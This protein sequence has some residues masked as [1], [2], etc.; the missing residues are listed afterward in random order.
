[1]CGSGCGAVSGSGPGS[2]SA[3]SRS[4]GA[5]AFVWRARVGAGPLTVLRVVDRF[6]DGAGSMDGRLFG[7]LRILHATGPDT[8]RSAAG[9]AALEAATF[10]PAVLLPELGV[11][12]RAESDESIARLGSRA[13]APGGEHPHRREGAIRSVS[14]PRW[15]NPGGGEWGYVPFGAVA[16]EERSFGGLVIPSSFTAGWWFGTPRFAPF[17]R[18]AVVRA[19]LIAAIESRIAS[20]PTTGGAWRSMAPRATTWSARDCSAKAAKAARRPRSPPRT[21]RPRFA[22]RAW[23]RR[24]STSSSARAR[25]RSSATRWPRAAA[26]APIP[27]GFTYLGQFL[28][29]DLTFDKTSVML[30]ANIS[31]AAMMQARSPSLDL[32]SLYGAGP[33][34]PDSA[35]FYEADGLHL[36]MGNDR[37]RGGIPAKHG[38]DLPRG[39]GQ[40]AGPRSARR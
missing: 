6:H 21:P 27:A 9:R 23:G 35:K 37:G 12:W 5:T 18:A 11:C 40:H 33:Q 20:A 14:G 29:H 19:V 38:F 39:A 24:A 15:G 16:H 26:G 8:S 22:S 7:R 1:M 32:D 28:D 30:G 25:A 3:P 36:K 31:P 2:P 34:D 13:R 10:A 4:A 17:F